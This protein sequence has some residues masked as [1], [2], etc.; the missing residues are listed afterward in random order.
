[1]H[2]RQAGEAALPITGVH[3]ETGQDLSLPDLCAD[4]PVFV[5]WIKT[6]CP[7][8]ERCIGFVERMATRL[9]D[10]RVVVVT[11]NGPDEVEEFRQAFDCP[12]VPT[13]CEPEPYHDADVYGLTNVP[14]W[15]VFASAGSS[16]QVQA[17]G[18]S[19]AP[20]ELQ[21]VY[22]SLG[23]EGSLFTDEE[24]EQLPERQPG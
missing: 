24:L 10:K 15:F 6:D 11:Q 9:P 16:Q 13:Y 21:A 1:M 12:T 8:C 22:R 5:F 19:F 4:G 23:G 2:I 14:T 18:M 7:V 3:A 17:S 20:A